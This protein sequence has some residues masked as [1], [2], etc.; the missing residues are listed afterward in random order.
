[1]ERND[2]SVN[3]MDKCYRRTRK[4]RSER[5][6]KGIDQ[7]EATHWGKQGNKSSAEAG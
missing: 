5:P 6:G 1:M 3:I 7:G 4:G 2:K